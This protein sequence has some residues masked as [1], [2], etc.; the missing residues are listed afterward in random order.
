MATYT[1]TTPYDA[2]TFAHFRSWALGYTTALGNFGWIQTNDTGQ[3]VWTA[4]SVNISQVAVVSLVATYTYDGTAVTGPALRV[5]MSINISGFVNG[6]NNV[7]ANI[8]AL[9][10]SGVT[11]TF[12]VVFS[13]QVNETH[14]ATGVT[15]AQTTVPS[16]AGSVYEVWRM[17]DSLQSTAPV[18]MILYYYELSNSPQVDIQLTHAMNGA[19]APATSSLYYTQLNYNFSNSSL[20]ITFYFSGDTNRFMYMNDP[21]QN[22]QRSGSFFIERAKDSSGNDI[23]SYVVVGGVRFQQQFQQTFFQNGSF[24]PT[25]SKF[26]AVFPNYEGAGGGA[27]VG[28]YIAVAPILPMIGGMGN[29]CIS[30]LIFDIN[31]FATNTSMTVSVYGITHTYLNWWESNATA[32]IVWSYAST[33]LALRYE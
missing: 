3:V 1:N 2:S 12:A 10:G 5:G 27:G 6:G 25:E 32:S 20:S 21:T 24:M 33:G 31:D 13:T 16:T 17:N 30:A 7:T 14:A 29:P 28:Q 19:G 15:I 9:G 8:T 23:A 22:F 26:T 11:S 4:T 18:F